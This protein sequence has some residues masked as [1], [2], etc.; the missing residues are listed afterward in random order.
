MKTENEAVTVND[1]GC[2]VRIIEITRNGKTRTFEIREGAYGLINKIGAG[3]NHNDLAKRQQNLEMFGA[4][5]IS[6][7]VFENGERITVE[8]AQ[9]L[10]GAIG[11]RLEKESLDINAMNAEAK[12]EAKNA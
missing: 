5:I 1:D 7:S 10:P 9:A 8:Q 3:L 4:N 6:A 12:D 11:K 2:E